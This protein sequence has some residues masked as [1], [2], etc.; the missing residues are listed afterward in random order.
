[1]RLCF[2]LKSREECVGL[3]GALNGPKPDQ[4]WPSVG[5]GCW[6]IGAAFADASSRLPAELL[7][8]DIPVTTA[9]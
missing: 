4:H 5:A 7:S 6:G 8:S 9:V 3:I 1:M 2:L